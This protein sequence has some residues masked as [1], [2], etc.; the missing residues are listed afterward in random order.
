[1]AYDWPHNEDTLELAFQS[2][3]THG[4]ILIFSFD[5]AGNGPWDK[6]VV[7]SYLQK[8]GSHSQY[9]K[10]SGKPLVSTFEG[11]GN[12]DDWIEIKARTNCFFMPDWSS[13]G[14]GPA[15]ALAG[16]VAD[17]LFSWAAWPWGNREMD[18]FVDASYLQA[19]NGKPYMM[20]VSPWFYTNLP[21]YYKN[22]L[23]SSGHLWYTRWQQVWDLQ[24]DYVQII[25][26]NDFGESHYIGG[27]DPKQ[28]EAFETGK[29]PF[30]YVDGMAHEGWRVQLPFMIDTY[31]DGKAT[32]TKESATVAHHRTSLLTGCSDGGT[33]LNTANQLQLEHQP[34]SGS[35]DKVYVAA[36]LTAP[37]S[38]SFS[39]G[40]KQ[41]S[42]GLDEWDVMPDGG[43]GLYLTTLDITTEG[44]QSLS[45][46]RN[47][48]QLQF[49][50]TLAEDRCPNTLTNWNAYVEG[51]TWDYRLSGEYTPELSL[52]EQVCIKGWS[53]PEFN[54][55]CEF[56]CSYGYCPLG[57]CV[58]SQV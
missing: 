25:S 7:I 45:I 33:T 32:F 34:A 24:P 2:A 22:W 43:V 38:I 27:L 49:F 9:W 30:N 17:G 1:M 4:L 26:W 12:A 20:P 18:T 57:A 15:L 35:P 16:G 41:Q 23:W 58:C 51:A 21:G 3:S 48:I 29:A 42:V 36:L 40:G 11:P 53:V 8:Y 31:V 56:T 19:L 28:Y 44:Y 37:A 5:Y 47:G 46:N 10:H 14:A 50:R 13:A 39:S 54:K 52:S 6:D 55:V